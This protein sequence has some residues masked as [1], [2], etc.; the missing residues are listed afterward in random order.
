[1]VI[2]HFVVDTMNGQIEDGLG[3]EMA[4][5]G[6]DFPGAQDLLQPAVQQPEEYLTN[7]I[8]T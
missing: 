3:M 6:W 2:K 8:G 5:W 7:E 4:C 1:M